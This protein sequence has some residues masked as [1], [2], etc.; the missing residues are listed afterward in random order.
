MTKPDL[1]VVAEIDGEMVPFRVPSPDPKVQEAKRLYE[2][3]WSDPCWSQESEC[4]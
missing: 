1:W 4:A 3:F 2:E